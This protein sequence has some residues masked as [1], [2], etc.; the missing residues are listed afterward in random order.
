ML[1]LLQLYEL[2]MDSKNYGEGQAKLREFQARLSNVSRNVVCVASLSV[3]P[4]TK[5]L[6]TEMDSESCNLEAVLFIWE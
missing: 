4:I 3:V 6:I 1:L 5:S 2:C